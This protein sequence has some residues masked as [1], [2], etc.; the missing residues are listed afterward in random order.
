MRVPLLAA[1][2]VTVAVSAAAD[3][4]DDERL[5]GLTIDAID[6]V[7]PPRE[8]LEQLRALA[9]LVEGEPFRADDVRRAVKLLYQLDRFENVYVF[10]RRV[11]NV[12]EL[13]FRLVPRPFIR[14][15]TI[16]SGGVLSDD[17]VAKALQLEVSKELAV[18]T[19]PDRR[20]TLKLA[21]ERIGYRSPAIGL[22]TRRADD[23]GGAEVVVRIDEG[24]V[25]RIRRLA[26][27]GD[28]TAS[29][30]KL[31]ERLGV[32]ASDVLDLD[33]IAAGVERIS[34]DYRRAGH[35]TVAIDPPRVVPVDR[36]GRTLA[37]VEIRIHA[38]PK[39]SIRF[40]GNTVVPARELDKATAEL[41][42]SDISRAAIEEARE[43]I[44]DL[45]ERRGY[46][47]ARVT[48]R[49]RTSADKSKKEIVFF[50]E[51][52]V[53]ARVVEV[54][55]PGNEEID[56]AL[57]RDKV[58]QVVEQALGEAS[59]ATDAD[60]DEIDRIITDRSG[61]G[62]VRV[63][64]HPA[65]PDP[66]RVYLER[67]YRLASDALE[68]FYRAEGFQTVDVREP[69]VE[70]RDEGRE[71]AVSFEV[72]PGVRW[73]IGAIA[74]T[75][76][77]LESAQQLLQVAGIEP[78]EPLSFYKVDDASRAI[79]NH[80]R[81]RG[82]LYARVDED[83]RELLPRGSLSVGGFVR[84]STSAPLD[85]RRVCGQAEKQGAQSCDVELVFRIREGVEVT[86][87]RIVVR[88]NE[89][90]SDRLVASELAIKEGKL[91]TDQDMAFTQANLVRLGVFRRATV[92]PIDEEREAADKDVLVELDE[93]KYHSFEVG[94]G[95]STEE[96]MRVFAGYAHRNLFGSAVRLQTNA[97]VNAQLF[98]PLFSEAVRD[99]LQEDPIEYQFGIG[100]AYPRILGLPRGFGLSGDVIVLRDNDPAFR[101]STRRVTLTADFKGLEPRIGGR[102]RP[103]AFRLRTSFDQ[104]AIECN[105]A[106]KARALCGAAATD[107]NRRVS[108]NTDYIGILPGISFDLRDDPLNPHGGIYF[109]LLPELLMGLNEESPA[110]LAL[111]TKLNGYIPLGSK[112]VLALSL[113]FQRIFV[114]GGDDVEI[115]VN[116][117]IAAGG[118]STIRGYRQ[119]TL[120]PID[121]LGGVNEVSP[122]GLLLA[123]LRSELRFPLAG[124]LAG[125]VFYDFGDLFDNPENFSVTRMERMS[126]GAGIRYATPIG[127]FLF[128]LAARVE[129]G[130]LG[131]LPHFAV[132]GSF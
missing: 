86:T 77:D 33:A 64:P 29:Q 114:F 118:R 57:L 21:Y 122:G 78:G 100:L 22:A 61:A 7:A 115:P 123:V 28:P 132:V 80:Y 3:E 30:W 25:T 70:V 37:D 97:R 46:W 93:R 131:F 68:D 48:P 41:R 99:F 53:R 128:D 113:I 101:D 43:R 12:V 127:P 23:N 98:F 76:N 13:R 5:E 55:F 106:V 111:R 1:L 121:N 65:H 112:A 88:G 95:L 82:L 11:G 9:G 119:D 117:R 102:R 74:M 17:D 39:I 31:R 58:V 59:V 120:F 105:D 85:L 49:S 83:L 19:F 87:R 90:T 4:A 18:A 69:Q 108:Q 51:P 96:G 71:L 52:G 20:R 44:A 75:G 36:Q 79:R 54:T 35:L 32:V 62:P 63:R 42:S 45:Y 66:A 16:V 14:E 94:A 10:G 116:R 126:F 8:N 72:R 124:E 107:V 2:F 91:L 125:A 67:A 81:N 24:P 129:D 104:S 27:V 40:I 110:H 130:A 109:E 6:L 89:K 60:A 15:I 92:R 84:T 50:I 26:V 34:T 47:K 56:V 103:L 38:G 73:R